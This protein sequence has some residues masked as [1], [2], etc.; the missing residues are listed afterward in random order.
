MI[1]KIT[2]LIFK[3]LKIIDCLIKFLINRSFMIWIREFF[4]DTSY[5]VLKI[6]KRKINFFTKIY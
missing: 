2:Y 3:F 1:K 5:K 4:H 6:N